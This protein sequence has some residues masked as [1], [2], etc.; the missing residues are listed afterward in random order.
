[1][2][3]KIK[4]YIQRKRDERLYTKL[5]F[6]FLKASVSNPSF[7]DNFNYRITPYNLYVTLAFKAI[8]GYDYSMVRDES[9]ILSK[10]I[11]G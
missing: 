5:M 3:K 6:I 8:R 9:G 2:F 1:M 4:L 11:G 7:Q 10:N